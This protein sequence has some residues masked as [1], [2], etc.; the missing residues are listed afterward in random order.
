[1]TARLLDGRAL[2]R[3]VRSEVAQQVATLAQRGV[4]PGLAVILAGDDGA[5]AIYVKNKEKAAAE[6]GIAGQVLR[7]PATVSAAE[8]SACIARLNAD[9][10]VHG[11]LVQLPLPS[12]IAPAEARALLE[13]VDPRKDVDGF[14]PANLGRLAAG[15]PG[16]VACTPAGCMRLLAEAGVHLAGCHAVVIGRSTIVGR[17]M[18]LLLLGADATVTI[19]HSRTTDLAAH[20]RRADVVVAAVGRARLVRGDWIKPGAA[21]ID[22]G[23]NRDADG[24]LCG[25]VHFDEAL[26]VAGALTPVPGGVGPMTIACL[27]ENVCRA[28]AQ[29]H[30]ATSAASIH[31][32]W[33]AEDR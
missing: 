17:P 12:S 11:I 10:A 31:S 26:A 13:Q 23:M 29:L 6:V 32:L 16:L 4:V 22:V 20:V 21:V 27:L 24:R 15:D 7:F 2:A 19:C 14:H 3:Q 33:P 8:L 9:P 18:A 25:D 28:A 1:M 5:S 30:P